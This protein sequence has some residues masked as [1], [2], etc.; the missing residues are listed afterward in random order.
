M[1]MLATESPVRSALTSRNNRSARLGS[2]RL[3]RE[4]P[5]RRRDFI[6][7]CL[8]NYIPTFSLAGLRKLDKFGRGAYQGF[9]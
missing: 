8:S 4:Q 5:S 6:R 2:P 3:V 1:L 9:S 7:L